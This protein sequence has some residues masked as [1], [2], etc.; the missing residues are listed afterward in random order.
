MRQITVSVTR[1]RTTTDDCGHQYHVVTGRGGAPSD[2][3]A[4]LAAAALAVAKEIAGRFPPG[5][6]ESPDAYWH[7][8]TRNDDGDPEWRFE[9]VGVQMAAGPLDSGEPG[10][11][12]FGTLASHYDSP[13]DLGWWDPK[14]APSLR[15]RAARRLAR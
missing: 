10:W 9:L 12:A 5:L 2:A 3:L 11:L 13:E 15:D 8:V 4:D 14:P 1:T 7:A 6:P